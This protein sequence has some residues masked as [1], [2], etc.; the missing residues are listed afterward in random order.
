MPP[1][2][3]VISPLRGESD[4]RSL[5]EKE[6]ERERSRSASPRASAERRT[7]DYSRMS[8]SVGFPRTCYYA[9]QGSAEL[10]RGRNAGE[11]TYS[12]GP[13]YA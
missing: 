11:R 1:E 3:Y 8:A 6:G 4:E 12:C 10:R 9:Y 13:L 5:V 7:A 2:G